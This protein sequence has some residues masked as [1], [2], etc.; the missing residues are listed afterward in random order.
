MFGVPLHLLL[1]HFPIAFALLAVTYDLRAHFGHAPELHETGYRLT[2][3]A[4]VAA[5]CA[6]LSGLQMGK[7][8][9]ESSESIAH[10]GSALLGVLCLVALMVL[11]Y[12]AKARQEE[13]QD[14][15]SMT[16]LFL[17]LLAGLAIAMAAITGHRFALG[18]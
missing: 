11:R 6:V 2:G 5:A 10:V 14:S 7:G 15:Y 17:G 4:S 8:R 18:N 12:S 16:W 9:L 1:V 3:W 13:G